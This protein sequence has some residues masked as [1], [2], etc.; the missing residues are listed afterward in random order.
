MYSGLCHGGPWHG[1]PLAFENPEWKVSWE[2]E[3]S[4]EATFIGQYVFDQD[5]WTWKPEPAY[6]AFRKFWPDIGG[7]P[8]AESTKE[9]SVVI[10][11]WK[12]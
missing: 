11:A 9:V 5:R 6:A 2:D 10:N 12:G 8:Q 4:G 7:H 1:Q 3:K